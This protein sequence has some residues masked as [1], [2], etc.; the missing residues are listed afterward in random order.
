MV[1]A[2]GDILPD[3]LVVLG[4]DNRAEVCGGIE[5]EARADT[6]FDFFVEEGEE[7]VVDIGVEE[8]AGAVCAYLSGGVEVRDHAGVDGAV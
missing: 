4:G 8:Y 2:V 7:G 6:C 5:R 1:D 3:L